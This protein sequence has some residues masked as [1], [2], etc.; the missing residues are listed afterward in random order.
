MQRNSERY[1]ETSVL[2]SWIA[3]LS[4]GKIQLI[5]RMDKEW[6]NKACKNSWGRLSKSVQM[7]LRPEE[8]P[9]SFSENMTQNVR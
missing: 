4:P 8:I 3:K 1:K 5:I 2:V 6:E 7:A 9:P